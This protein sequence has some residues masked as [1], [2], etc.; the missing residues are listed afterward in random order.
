MRE[1]HAGGWLSRSL[2]PLHLF[3]PSRISAKPSARQAML[4]IMPNT[5]S[6]PEA[7]KQQITPLTKMSGTGENSMTVPTDISTTLRIWT[8]SDGPGRTASSPELNSGLWIVVFI[9]VKRL[10]KRHPSAHHLRQSNTSGCVALP[11]RP[12]SG[13][14]STNSECLHLENYRSIVFA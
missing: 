5:S 11:I 7:P 12:L 9:V 10:W 2:L 3:C 8:A 14:F 4:K 6:Q 1:S 13:P